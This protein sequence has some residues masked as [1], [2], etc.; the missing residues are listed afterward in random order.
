[1]NSHGLDLNGLTKAQKQRADI[2][3]SY[4]ES[5]KLKTRSVKQDIA[6]RYLN[7]FSLRSSHKELN[8]YLSNGN[9]TEEERHAKIDVVQDGWTQR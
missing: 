1:M 4:F 7:C 2:A 5:R 9:L 3:R 6:E 8:M